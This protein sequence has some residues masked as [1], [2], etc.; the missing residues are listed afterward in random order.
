MKSLFFLLMKI[1]VENAIIIPYG[2]IRKSMPTS[3]MGKKI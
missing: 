1:F 2:K 3:I